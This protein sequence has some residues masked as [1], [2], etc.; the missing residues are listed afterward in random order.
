MSG[1]FNDIESLSKTYSRSPVVIY[2]M[3]H[4]YSRSV[5]RTL[6]PILT[7]VIPYPRS[8]DSDSVGERGRERI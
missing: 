6:G 5:L 8:L 1:K 4:S 2:L 3:H 7:V